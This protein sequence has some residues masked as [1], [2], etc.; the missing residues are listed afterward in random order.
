MLSAAFATQ[1]RFARLRMAERDEYLNATLAHRAN[2]LAHKRLS[3]YYGGLLL[4]PPFACP[5]GLVKTISD[6]R[7][8]VARRTNH[9]ADGGKWLCGANLLGALR[10]PCRVYSIGSNA[11]AEFEEFVEA[12]VRSRSPAVGAREP[13]GAR[14]DTHIYDPT[15]ETNHGLQARQRFTA[16]VERHGWRLHEI[17]LTASRPGERPSASSQSTSPGLRASRTVRITGGRR[18]GGG[19]YPAQTLIEMVASNGHAP[20]T[21]VDVLKIDVDS[22]EE[23]VPSPMAH[24]PCPTFLSCA[25][26]SLY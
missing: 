11:D 22:Y 1:E 3:T 7:R 6:A 2:G 14:C 20:G 17:A 13:G 23:D 15:I 9:T 21:C 16:H 4:A 5:V 10:R 18:T 8:R 12:H 25:M 26:G 19:L 24:S